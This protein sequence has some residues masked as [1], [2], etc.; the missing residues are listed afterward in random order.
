MTPENPPAQDVILKKILNEKLF[1]GVRL[2]LDN[3][4]ENIIPSSGISW[5]FDGEKPIPLLLRESFNC[6][7]VS[8]QHCSR[9][10]NAHLSACIKKKT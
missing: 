6:L 9:T 5:P 3:M 4:M 2:F 8:S 1:G 10:T 7:F